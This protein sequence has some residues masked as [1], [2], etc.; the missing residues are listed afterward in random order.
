M[1]TKIT[2]LVTILE[3]LIELLE[4]DGE[5]NWSNCIKK[6]KQRILASDYSGIEQLLGSYGGMGSFNDLIICQSTSEGRFQ[7]KPGHKEKNEKLFELRNMAWEVANEIKRG[8]S[9]T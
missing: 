1:D 9:R 5:N 6:S 3:Q 4:S 2:Q 8:Q 7:W